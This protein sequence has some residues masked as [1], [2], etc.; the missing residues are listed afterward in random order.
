MR[1]LIK[2]TKPGSECELFVWEI[3]VGSAAEEADAL[4]VFAHYQDLLFP[5]LEKCCQSKNVT[6]TRL[7]GKFY[8]KKERK[9]RRGRK[10]K[11][12]LLW[13]ENRTMDWITCQEIIKEPD[14]KFLREFMLETRIWGWNNNSR[15]CQT[16][17]TRRCELSVKIT[18]R[19]TERQRKQYAN[20]FVHWLRHS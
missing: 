17:E 5:A 4:E 3:V 11:I 19:T 7:Q 14:R 9:K 10:Y 1:T 12:I 2:P 16:R 8:F 20:P 6:Y 15:I 18:C 13:L